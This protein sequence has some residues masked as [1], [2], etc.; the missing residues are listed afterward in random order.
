MTLLKVVEGLARTPAQPGLVG[1]IESK[2]SL[3]ERLL[4]IAHPGSARR[5]R[6]LAVGVTIVLAGIGLTG[7]QS[8]REPTRNADPAAS[9]TN[10][11]SSGGAVRQTHGLRQVAF[12]VVD[13]DTKAPVES[14]GIHFALTYF[15][16]NP[17]ETNVS[18]WQGRHRAA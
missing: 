18:Y 12:Q 4:A 16:E 15:G 13:F 11:T 6:W 17:K 10:L 14:A 7:A 1:I 3:K 9:S 5:W 2:A 8:N